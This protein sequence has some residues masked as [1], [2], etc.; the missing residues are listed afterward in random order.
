MSQNN[1]FHSLNYRPDIDGLRGLAVL[2]VIG[3]HYFP[4]TVKGGFI[5]VDIFFVISGFLISSIIINDINNSNFSFLK[6]YGSRIRRIFPVLTII[7]FSVCIFGYFFLF[8]DEYKSL[9]KHIF[10]GSFY[11]N[12][13]ILG[14]E[15]DYFDVS[16]KFN[17]LLHLWSLGI[18]EQ[19]YLCLPLLLFFAKKIKLNYL[20]LI[21]LFFV[22]SLLYNVYFCKIDYLK[23]FYYPHT[24]F[25]ELLAGSLLYF[26]KNIKISFLTHIITVLSICTILTCIF[27]MSPN[28]FPGLK[29]LMP[30]SATCFI[31]SLGKKS[32]INS[33]FFSNKLIVNIGLI[34]YP[35]YLWH[36]PLYSCFIIKNNGILSIYNKII[37]I[38]LTIILSFLSFKFIEKYIRFNIEYRKLK[39]I[40]LVTFI[41]II[42]I[43]GY[44]IYINQGFNNRSNMK[45]F[46]SI[47]ID[48]KP[49]EWM[50]DCSDI[51]QGIG[52]FPDLMCS[53]SDL[54]S[55]ELVAVFGD[56]HGLASFPGIAKINSDR[57]VGTIF[58]GRPGHFLPYNGLYDYLNI[59][60]IRKIWVPTTH[61]IYNAI[62]NTKKINKVFIITRGTLYLDAK[63]TDYQTFEFIKAIPS[64]IYEQ[65]IQK[66][67]DI[68]NSAGKKVYIVTES[69][70][71]PV[72]VI[73][74]LRPT[75]EPNKTFFSKQDVINHQQKYLNMINNIKNA[76]IIYSLD[77]LCPNNKC[78]ITD[79]NGRPLFS[80]DD[81]FS[82]YGSVFQ[83]EKLL[84]NYLV[85]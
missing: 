29:A 33:I 5:G 31:I 12:N 48:T 71:L 62:I 25:W 2:S 3:F 39:T 51:I 21:V 19:F 15:N 76:T 28:L 13:I 17:P 66:T 37:L 50:S 47:L 81:H 70:V 6:F 20:F 55:E 72:P 77:V 38:I 63:D 11:I 60:V 22:F 54:D 30:I 65:A 82:Y 35:M 45:N 53:Y 32:F 61:I 59:E 18:E 83:A 1:T 24:R 42:G 23:N 9:G 79:E 26:V 14:S 73:N 58:I 43:M 10:G 52:K 74:L 36:W 16:N 27:V 41:S 75:V 85:E 57:G 67:V 34:S 4:E 84:K 8:P 49:I 80:D 64:E 78:L 69:P 44:I 46:E 7:L 40:F 68:F 56:S